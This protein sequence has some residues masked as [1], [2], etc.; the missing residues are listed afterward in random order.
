MKNFSLYSVLII[1]SIGFLLTCN[2]A[3]GQQEISV[4]EKIGQMLMVGFKGFAITDTSHIV[5]DIQEYH[6]G[7]VILFDYDVPT[8]TANR[9]I[10]SPEQVRVLNQRLQELADY[11]LFLAVDQEGGRV[12][13]LK[14][15]RNFLNHVS[16]EYLGN[17]DNPDSTKFYANSMSEQ[18]K[19]LGFNVNFAPV[20]DLNTNPD[21]PVIGKLE[22]SFG[23]DPELVTR[24]AA[25][26]LEEFEQNGVVGVLKHF[27]GHGSAWNDSHVGMADVTDT[28]DESELEPYQNLIGSGRQFAIMT[29]HVFN[30][31]L[32]PE[33]PATL[34]SAV[35][36]N[37]LRNR[38]GFEGVLFSDDM[39]MDAIRSFYG[40]ET[41][42]KQ[43]IYAGVDV[44]VFG[45]NSVYDPGIVPKAVEIIKSLLES[46][47]I[48]EE[49]INRSYNRIMRLKN[50]LTDE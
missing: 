20:V 36:T 35:Q 28:W 19:D 41:A 21:N 40:L 45:N 22:R 14:P 8:S 15:V 32:D 11:P 12:A 24:H 37:L 5:R 30:E 3:A 29:A 2:S 26:F 10:E 27:P 39:Q 17:L 23:E 6:T 9:N 31:N 33:F 34:S 25:I 7:G 38:L 16:A 1:V 4:D 43:A 48:T 50:S 44:L 42:I 49:R 46:G 13:R 47:E 18:L